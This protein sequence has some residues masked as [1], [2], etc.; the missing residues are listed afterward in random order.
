MECGS[1]KQLFF[2]IRHVD[3]RRKIC[4]AASWKN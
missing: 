1:W 4:A 3:K 2:G